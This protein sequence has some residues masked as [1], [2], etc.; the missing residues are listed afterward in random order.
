MS[1]IRDMYHD[2]SF[3]HYT[4]TEDARHLQ[5]LYDKKDE[6]EPQIREKCGEL[7]TAYSQCIA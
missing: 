6:L 1:M 3:T 7:F 4:S 2:G 5:L